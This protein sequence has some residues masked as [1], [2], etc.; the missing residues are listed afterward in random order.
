MPLAETAPA[1]AHPPLTSA[2]GGGSGRR[3]AAGSTPRR[4]TGLVLFVVGCVFTG[5]C[6]MVLYSC[7]WDDHS[8][9]AHRG[10]AIADV[11]SVSFNRTAVGFVTPDGTAHIPANGVLY[12]LGLKAGERIRVEYDTQNP[13]VVRVAGR[14]FTLAFLP[15]GTTLAGSWM[16]LGPVIWWLRRRR[17]DHPTVG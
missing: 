10:Q 7:W 2:S 13:D 6:L 3:R 12:P 11:L 9:N 14:N 15:V 5:L 4:I 17:P 16:V 8:I 1:T